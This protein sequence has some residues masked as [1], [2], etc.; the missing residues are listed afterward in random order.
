MDKFRH[1]PLYTQ[2]NALAD[3]PAIKHAEDLFLNSAMVESEEYCLR[4][5]P[6]KY[7]NHWSD[8]YVQLG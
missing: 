3:I 4:L 8:T 6:K 7:V 2:D 1:L 5:D